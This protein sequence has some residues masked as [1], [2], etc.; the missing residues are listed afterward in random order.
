MARESFVWRNGQ[1]VE[2]NGPLDVRTPA[3]RSELAC[4][5]VIIDTMGETKSM[6]NGKIYTS[7]SQLRAHY[8]R[9]GYIEMGSDAPTTP[10][11][12]APIDSKQIKADVVAAYQKVKAGYKPEYSPD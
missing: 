9:D 4:P 12:R 6:G 2:K 5:M 11:P 10:P 1:V 3:P 7:K 8:K